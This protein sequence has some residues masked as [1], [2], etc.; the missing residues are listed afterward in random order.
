[1]KIVSLDTLQSLRIDA[2]LLAL[3]T[4][5]IQHTYAA[6]YWPNG[7]DRNIARSG[8]SNS[9]DYEPLLRDGSASMCCAEWNDRAPAPNA[10]GLCVDSDDVIWRESCSD[11]SWE[12]PS[13]LKLCAEGVDSS[14]APF[15]ATDVTIAPCK[16]G[17]YCCGQENTACC[18]SRDG[19][20][21][22]NGTAVPVKP[23]RRTSST[24]RVTATGTATGT[25]G[26]NGDQSQSGS[27]QSG[28]SLGGGAI[29]GIVIGALAGVVAVVAMV[30]LLL[31]R[32][33][34]AR[35]QQQALVQGDY[36]EVVQA[37]P[38]ELDPS[39]T[40]YENDA[41]SVHELPVPEREVSLNQEAVQE[42][43]RESNSVNDDAS[44]QD[45]S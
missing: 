18:D 36:K 2:L 13:C 33:R 8:Y 26:A 43:R 25:G 19:F 37:T 17:S 45:G 7:Q 29:A 5:A 9:T 20:F 28:K 15:N 24:M 12:S 3:S 40:L 22:Q 38:A 1:M 23:E 6:C 27:P 41:A 16:D 34:R 30:L 35:K 39:K 42:A 4:V 32:H 21:L 44:A 11:R 14:G 10:F 31:K